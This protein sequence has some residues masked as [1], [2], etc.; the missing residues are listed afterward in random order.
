LL[1]L[2]GWSKLGRSRMAGSGRLLLTKVRPSLLPKHQRLFVQL[3]LQWS[4]RLQWA[5]AG[6]IRVSV[7]SSVLFARAALNMRGAQKQILSV[8]VVLGRIVLE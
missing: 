6:D 4:K 7:E 8:H 3:R 5:M 2:I 1:R